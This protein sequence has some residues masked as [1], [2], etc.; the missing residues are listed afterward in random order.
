MKIGQHQRTIGKYKI[1]LAH[2]AST[3]TFALELLKSGHFAQG[4][5]VLA[6]YQT[7]G[8]GRSDRQWNSHPGEN[9]LGSV[10]LCHDQH[11]HGK[12]PG[13]ISMIASLAVFRTVKAFTGNTVSIKWPN[14]I[15]IE[16]KK[17]AGI[18]IT[19]HWRGKTL[20]SSILGIGL[21]VNQLQFDELPHATSLKLVLGCEVDL[22]KLMETLFAQLEHWYSLLKN[23]RLEEIHQVYQESMYGYQQLIN[24]KIKDQAT[25]V[26]AKLIGTETNGK[27]IIEV[28]S[29]GL[30]TFDLDE[31]KI[32][33]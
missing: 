13:Y 33:Y 23:N 7:E 15:L 30:R 4:A 12:E 28:V 9:F 3:Q 25:P 24:I 21:N 11:M 18:L 5:I 1:L 17:V 29:L 8:K 19:N 32:V 14:D 27:I 31:I 6:E 26:L 2:T 16:H 22:Q 10:L 20:E